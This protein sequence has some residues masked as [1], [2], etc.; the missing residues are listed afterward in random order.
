MTKRF[1]CSTS[2]RKYIS[3]KV[4]MDKKQYNYTLGTAYLN[5]NYYNLIILSDNTVDKIKIHKKKKDTLNF[6]SL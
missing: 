3:K 5:I 6:N 4:I 2:N 1:K